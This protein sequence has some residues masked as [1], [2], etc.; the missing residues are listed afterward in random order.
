LDS[1]HR[2]FTFTAIATG[3]KLSLR[4]K[5]I[6]SPELVQEIV[7][8]LCKNIVGLRISFSGESDEASEDGLDVLL[9]LCHKKSA[10]KDEAQSATTHHLKIGHGDPL[11]QL[12][13][14]VTD[15]H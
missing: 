9:F 15:D 10:G 13:E 3:I 6:L 11:C 1:V 8:S 2:E 14:G 4:S 5:E 12:L 7:K